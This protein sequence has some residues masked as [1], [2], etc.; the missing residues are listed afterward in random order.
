MAFVVEDGTG[1]STATSYLSVADFRTHHTDRGT[2]T[3]AY[4]DT[5]VQAGLVKATDYVD[6]RFGRKFRGFRESRDQALEWPRLSA[7][8]NDDYLFNNE[9]DI[10]R[11]L[12]K[13]IAE[14]ALLAVQLTDLLPTPARPYPVLDPA[15]GT[16]TSVESGKMTA[17]SEKVG[18]IEQAY[19][20]EKG[21]ISSVLNSTPTA[22]TSAI[23]SGAYLPAYPVA[24]EWLQELIQDSF[25]VK[26][27]RG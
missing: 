10:P 27:R 1:L 5:A 12:Q 25:P 6:K 13:A 23:V 11:Q 15:T 20:F 22:A 8:D 18:P 16:V 21:S 3:S 24:D 9:D 26:L 7:F 17:K 19:E 14:Y 4:D 2:D